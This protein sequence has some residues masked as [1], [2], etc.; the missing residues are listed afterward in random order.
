MTDFAKEISAGVEHVVQ[1]AKNISCFMNLKN[2]KSGESDQL[3]LL[4]KGNVSFIM[5]H[6]S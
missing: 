1:F 5:T 3:N 4:K 6:N 2:A